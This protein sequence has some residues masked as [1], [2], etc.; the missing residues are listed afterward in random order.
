M[1]V[2]NSRPV[3]ASGKRHAVIITQISDQDSG[4]LIDLLQQ[5]QLYRF[6]ELRCIFYNGYPTG[7]IGQFGSSNGPVFSL[8]DIQTGMSM[9]FAGGAQGYFPWRIPQS[10]KLLLQDIAGLSYNNAAIMLLDFDE[11]AI[12]PLLL[13]TIANT[14]LSGNIGVNVINQ[15]LLVKASGTFPISGSIT[16]VPYQA[17]KIFSGGASAGAILAGTNTIGFCN[18]NAVNLSLPANSSLIISGTGAG[19]NYSIGLS[20][21]AALVNANFSMSFPCQFV[22]T[23]HIQV[24]LAGVTSGDV[25]FNLLY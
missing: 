9:T 14:D 5:Q 19:Q 1:F 20:G 16:A 25:L 15:P 13:P 18:L 17:N 8:V 21:A 6:G 23:T 3:D 10:P 11:A 2:Q 24:A 22:C 4:T 12:L 7:L